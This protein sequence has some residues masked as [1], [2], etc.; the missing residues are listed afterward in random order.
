M[1]GLDITSDALVVYGDDTAEVY[2]ISR[3]EDAAAF[4]LAG[5]LDAR[6][7]AERASSASAKRSSG[8]GVSGG[9]AGNYWGSGTSSGAMAL[10]AESVF[11]LAGDKVEVCNFGGESPAGVCGDCARVD[12]LGQSCCKLL[13]AHTNQ[14][15]SM[16]TSLHSSPKPFNT[17]AS[18]FLAVVRRN[19]EADPGIRP[20]C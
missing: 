8:A 20:G 1:R 18:L 7:C 13:T 17:L 4:S 16:Y 11:R 5:Q 2:A 6:G 14:Q 12:R 9:G 10:I 15:H 19:H 3:S